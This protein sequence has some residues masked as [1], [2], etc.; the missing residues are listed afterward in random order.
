[1]NEYDSLP[2]LDWWFGNLHCEIINITSDDL[3]TSCNVMVNGK[4][5]PSE[6]RYIINKSIHYAI[7]DAIDLAKADAK[8]A[9]HIQ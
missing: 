8:E 1:M 6:G 5:F 4:V 7:L 3:Q 2:C 9:G